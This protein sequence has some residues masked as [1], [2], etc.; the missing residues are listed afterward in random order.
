MK[1]KGI[2]KKEE[3]KFITRYDLTYETEEH[4]EKIYEII[5]R[6]KNIE[7]FEQLHGNRADAVVIIATDKSNKRILLNK[8]YRMAVGDWVYN[9]PAGL[10]DAG[11]TPQQA[12]KRELL[13]ETGLELYEIEDFIGPSYS[14]VGFS[15]EINVCVVGRAQGEFQKS[16]SALEEII[17]GWYTKSEIKELLKTNRFAARTQGYCYLW[18]KSCD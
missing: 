6:N 16:T 8:E 10:I 2:E 4:Q 18:S 12:A 15:N 1:F 14:A 11:E 9:F 5:S 3:G 13:E 7:S 17:P